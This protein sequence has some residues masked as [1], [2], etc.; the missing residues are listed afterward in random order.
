MAK[1]P[2][3]FACGLYDRMVPLYAGE[4]SPER[5]DLK[6]LP[7][8]APRDIF[9]RMAGGLEFDAAEM[10]SSEL[11]SRLCAGDRS[12]VAIPVFPSRMFRHG[13]ISV[14]RQT[15]KTPK[16]LEGKR[17]G[18]PLHTMTAAIF[19]RGMLQH[20][21]GVDL[22][23]IQW[24]QGAINSAGAHGSP[25]VLPLLKP[26]SIENN[27]TGKSLSDLL[28]EGSI[29]AIIGT[30]LPLA[31][32]HNPNIQRMCPN[33]QEVE[34]DYYLR[35]RI[36]PIMH[37]VALRRDV[38]ERHPFIAKSL[39]DALSRSKQIALE[40]MRGLVALQYMLPW[41]AA[42]IE[43]ID[44]VFGGDPWPYGVEAN[45]P[46]LE[47]LVTYMVEQSLI[48]NAIPVEDIFVPVWG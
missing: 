2:L 24:V 11:I 40:R 20:D 31:M 23:T 45:R 10:S 4:V 46:T 32:R 19:I 27:E 16:D 35:T 28:D 41:M 47:A 22:S 9:D 43:E 39:Y 26:V 37:L 29:D 21:H 12:F 5:I 25:S 1:L 3:T 13:L 6:F 17:V 30:R 7:N 48:A 18:V 34:R 8:P 15:V 42:D 44:R 33:F 14:N 36:F 38:Y